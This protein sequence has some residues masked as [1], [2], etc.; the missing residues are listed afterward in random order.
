MQELLKTA[1][2]GQAFETIHD[3]VGWAGIVSEG[4]KIFRATTHSGL[5]L[6]LRKTHI[7]YEQDIQN[8]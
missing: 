5:E 4:H 7:N 8:R 6:D 3:S 1:K 2:A